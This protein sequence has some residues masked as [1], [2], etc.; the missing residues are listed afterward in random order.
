M[1]LYAMQ[2][3]AMPR[4]VVMKRGIP[5]PFSLSFSKDLLDQMACD[6]IVS[7]DGMAEI[8]FPEAVV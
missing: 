5:I 7:P 4:E 8:P 2:L 1:S 3:A 6:L